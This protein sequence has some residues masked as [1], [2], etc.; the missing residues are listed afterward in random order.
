MTRDLTPDGA[1]QAVAAVFI[2]DVIFDHETPRG[3]H[4]AE[5][6]AAVEFCRE[7]AT[8]NDCCDAWAKYLA[9]WEDGP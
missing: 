8:R 9:R 6:C 2:A 3:K 5:K 4:C 1:R 7:Y